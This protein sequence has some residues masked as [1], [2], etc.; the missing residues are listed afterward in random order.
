MNEI[1]WYNCIGK[2]K[3]HKG[4]L[5][6]IAV[7]PR[8][9]TWIETQRSVMPAPDCIVVP[10]AGTWIET[11]RAGSAEI[12]GRVVPRAGTWIETPRVNIAFTCDESFPVRE[13]GLKPVPCWLWC[14]H[15]LPVVPRAGTWIE[16]AITSYARH[17]TIRR[18]P[19]GNV[20]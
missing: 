19:C 12:S 17:F 14:L 11:E 10:R 5:W 9:G 2:S 20:D 4:N 1:Y 18:S 13:R 6:M 7:V 8:A 3:K 16:S 15:H